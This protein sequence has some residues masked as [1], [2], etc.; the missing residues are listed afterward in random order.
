MKDKNVEKKWFPG[1][2]LLKRKWAKKDEI[3][4]DSDP[5]NRQKDG[6]KHQHKGIIF[7]VN[8][9]KGSFGKVMLK[10][11]NG[12]YCNYGL[13]AIKV[14][15]P[16]ATPENTIKGKTIKRNQNDIMNPTSNS[17]TTTTSTSSAVINYNFNTTKYDLSRYRGYDENDDYKAPLEYI[18]YSKL[19][20]R[21]KMFKRGDEIEYKDIDND[22]IKRGNIISS[23]D[24]NKS[25]KVKLSTG[26]KKTINVFYEKIL[27]GVPKLYWQCQFCGFQNGIKSQRCMVCDMNGIEI[28]DKNG[29]KRPE[30]KSNDDDK[31]EKKTQKTEKELPP[32]FFVYGTLRDDDDSGA[33]WG[34][35]T[36]DCVANNGKLYGY[37]MYQNKLK[38]Y[39]FAVKA[40]KKDFIVGRI[41]SWNDVD[42]FKMKLERADEIEGYDDS[43]DTD[44]LYHRQVVECENTDNGQMI[45][46]VF[47]FQDAPKDLDTSCYA[48]PNGDWLQRKK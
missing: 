14:K 23:D 9:G 20:F 7:M 2:E 25:F 37:K 27:I 15:L 24:K 12:G 17:S 47:Y 31:E 48:V 36:K 46:A 28:S 26:D 43:D 34:D 5:E 35:W 22:E 45:D 16:P 44:N 4:Y 21:K 3:E 18:K 10:D 8:E 13:E 41:V 39:P 30:I 33:A 6:K 42:I 11:E 1:T 40:E 38:K 32:R 29:N 19:R